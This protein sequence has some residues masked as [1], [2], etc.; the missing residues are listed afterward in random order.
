[1]AEE[2]SDSD[3][4]LKIAALL[5]T[6]VKKVDGLSSDVRTNSFRFDHM[7]TRF[8]RMETKVDRM[9]TRFDRMETRFDQLET[10]VDRIDIDLK[11]LKSDVQTLSGQ[12]SDVGVMA[13]KDHKRVDN[14]EER[15]D[16]LESEAH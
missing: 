16:I 2:I 11:D 5:D 9:E 1:M 15:V 12:F 8:D 3:F 6:V 14:L 4:K 10:K 7:E 13:I